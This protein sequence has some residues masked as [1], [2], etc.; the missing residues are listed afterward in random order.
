MSQTFS[1]N[2]ASVINR[3]T[4]E[5]KE[6]AAESESESTSSST[7]GAGSV[8]RLELRTFNASAAG[9][10]RHLRRYFRHNIG[11]DFPHTVVAATHTFMDNAA[12]VTIDASDPVAYALAIQQADLRGCDEK[13][14]FR[15][16][17]RDRRSEH[18]A[19]L[20]RA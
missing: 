2:H 14:T 20:P 16:G 6:F 9:D 8:D 11:V 3:E 19:P 7:F 18:L 5:S 1:Q 13:K 17:G 12:A 4:R 10:P 15:Q